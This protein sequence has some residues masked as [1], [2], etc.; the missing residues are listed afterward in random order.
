MVRG[1]THS[2]FVAAT[3]QLVLTTVRGSNATSELVPTAG[4]LLRPPGRG[5]SLPCRLV[6]CLLPFPAPLP[7]RL[8]PHPRGSGHT[9]KRQELVLEVHE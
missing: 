8:S 3:S 5:S 4:I 1:P 6:G 9:S 7:A 2:N